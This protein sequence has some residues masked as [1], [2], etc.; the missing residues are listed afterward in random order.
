MLFDLN[1][2]FVFLKLFL[3]I[4]KLGEL[5]DI[6]FNCIIFGNITMYYQLI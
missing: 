5:N 3:I 4:F 2:E 6:K 1:F